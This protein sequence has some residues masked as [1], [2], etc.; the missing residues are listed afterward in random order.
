MLIPTV[1]GT[2]VGALSSTWLHP[3]FLK[4]VLLGAMVAIALVMLIFPDVVAP[5]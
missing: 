5:P 3:D 4:P 1:S 2:A